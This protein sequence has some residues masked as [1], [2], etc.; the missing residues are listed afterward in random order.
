MKGIL[1]LEDG[2]IFQGRIFGDIKPSIGEVCF[3]TSMAGYQ[4]IITDPSYC[5]QI[6]VMSYPIIGNYGANPDDTESFR[7]F[8]A[9]FVVREYCN[10]PSNPRMAMTLN[11]FLKS[12]R[13]T[14]ISDVDTRALV[15]HIREKG[16]MRAAIAPQPVDLEYLKK[17]VLAHPKLDGQDLASVVTTGSLYHIGRPRRVRILVYDFGVKRNIIRLLREKAQ[18]TVVPSDFPVEQIFNLKP[19]GVVL[20]NG[21]GDPAAVNYAIRNIRD[22][23]GKVPILGICLGHQLL[24]LALNGKTF[25]LKFGHHGG[26]HPVKELRSGKV[27]ITVQNHSFVLDPESIEKSG[28]EITH[29]NLNDQT[30]EGFYHQG[31]KIYSYQFHPEARPGP[32]EA[33]NLIHKFVQVCQNGKT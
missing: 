21:P 5:G 22:L 27:L 20:S 4:E 24:G 19:S 9:G 30:L 13:V 12:Q 10:Y 6:V 33:Q 15:R 11:Q 32:T 7:A 23:L 26:N 31:Y 1:Y 14:A 17:K 8:L 3:N 16:E 2:R 25:R 28:A 29:I 18:V